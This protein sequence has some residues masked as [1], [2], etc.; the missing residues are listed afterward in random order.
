MLEAVP[1]VV[2]DFKHSCVL[3]PSCLWSCG[4]P[5]GSLCFLDSLF[6]LCFSV[7]VQFLLFLSAFVHSMPYIT[8]ELNV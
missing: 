1:P 6:E 5:C 8:M 7:H 3:F 2:N 4:P